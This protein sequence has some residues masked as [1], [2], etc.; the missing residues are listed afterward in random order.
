MVKNSVMLERPWYQEFISTMI[1]NI[2][3]PHIFQRVN[4]RSLLTI[5]YI[6]SAVYIPSLCNG[7]TSLKSL[8][9][10]PNRAV[11]EHGSERL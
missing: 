7:V 11:F 3:Q 5:I 1:G 6:G 2:L 8:W 10:A 9:T 4:K